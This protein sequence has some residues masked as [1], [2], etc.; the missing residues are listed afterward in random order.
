MKKFIFVFLFFLCLTFN[1][2]I[3][4]SMAATQVIKRGFYTI[5][6]LNLSP[7][8]SYTIQNNSFDER[9]YILVLDSSPNLLQS[10]RLRPQSP[11][12]NLIPLQAGYKIVVVGNGEVT[13]Y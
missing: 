4:P 3:V 1:I 6:T 10:I 7:N 9:I 13:I 5:D 12:Y 11:K 8:I 2:N